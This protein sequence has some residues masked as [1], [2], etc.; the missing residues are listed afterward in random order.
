MPRLHLA[1]TF[2]LVLIAGCKTSGARSSG[3]ET[4]PDYKPGSHKHGFVWLDND[5]EWDHV[6]GLPLDMRNYGS[7]D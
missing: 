7:G 6:D 1:A 3:Q 2:V 5:D 4:P